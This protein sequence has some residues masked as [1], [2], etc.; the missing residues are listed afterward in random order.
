[1]RKRSVL[2]AAKVTPDIQNDNIEPVSSWYGSHVFNKEVMKVKL[3][4][5]MYKK[6]CRCIEGEL[7]LDISIANE[8]AHA[9]KEWALENGAMHYAHWF[10][11]LTGSTAEKHDSFIGFDE[12]GEIIERFSGKELIKQEPD[13]SSFPSGGLRATFEAR[14]YTAWDPTSPSFLIETEKGMTLCI[15]SVFVTY[16]GHSLDQKSPLLRSLAALEEVTVKVAALFNNRVEKVCSNVGPE[17]EYFLTD[18]KLAFLRPDLILTGR[19][20]FGAPPAKG[21]QLD[22]Q[23]FG[24]IKERMLSFMNDVADELYRLGVP[25]KTRHNEV[26]PHQFEFAP[27]FEDA[28]LASDHNQLMMNV[29]EK[30]AV[31]HGFFASLHEKP[32]AGINGSGKHINWSINSENI[33]FFDPGDKPHENIQFLVFL[34]A[35]L[36][37]VYKH[38]GLLRA[39]IASASNDHR[40]GGNEAPPAVISVFLGTELS[41]VIK[42]LINEKINENALQEIIDLRISEIPQIRRDNTDRNRT[43]PFAFTGNK[44]EFRAAGSAQSISI[45]VTVLN[46]AVTESLEHI[47]DRIESMDKEEDFIKNVLSVLQEVAREVSDILFE[48]D[49]YSEEWKKEAERRGLPVLSTAPEAFEKLISSESIELFTRYK[50]FS[51]EEI[52]ARY[53]I[54]MEKYEKTVDIEARTALDIAKTNILPSALRYQKDICSSYLK[55]NEAGIE[56]PGLRKKCM[57]IAELVERLIHNLEN[58]DKVLENAGAENGLKRRAFFYAGEVLS[59]MDSLRSTVDSIEKVVDDEYWRLPKYYE[60]LFID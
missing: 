24:N 31:R 41:N 5:S 6:V 14:G 51:A 52:H 18:R 48:G 23:Y 19:T 29:I 55:A 2:N 3:S 49:N 16:N 50:V 42:K 10:Q 21:Q 4:K 38:S 32:F 25:V 60:L 46:T 13:A 37:G 57:E 26:A 53:E 54:E 27:I 28:N 15:P 45:P 12:N 36:R 9:M 59:Q 43:S 7:D 44:F 35:V 20:L 11:P 8:V 34:I 56:M 17:Q 1:M 33:N 30:V 22:D 40:L 58:M 39:S 47:Y